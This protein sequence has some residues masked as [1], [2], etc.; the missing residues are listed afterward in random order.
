MATDYDSQLPVRSK[1]D[2]DERVLIKV[3]DG[4][5]PDGANETATVADKRLHTKAHLSDFSGN[6]YTENN[7]LPTYAAESP[8][9]EI[10]DF[11]DA[12]AI[13]KNASANHDY[14][15]S[16]GKDLKD[17]EVPCS[18]SGKARFE[19]LIETAAASGV[20]TTAAVGF[21]STAKPNIELIY[22]K[23][24]ATGV[25]VRVTKTNLDNQPQSLYSQVQGLEI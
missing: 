1:Q 7:P 4:D 9:D 3:Q 17:I 5:N 15:V 13:V 18:A 12:D 19:L 8:G 2:L 21:N 25:I 22:K 20:F 10:D 11:D 6:E 23:K 16:A 24:V 14:T